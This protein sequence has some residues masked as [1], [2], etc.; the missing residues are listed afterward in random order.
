MVRI[1]D[2]RPGKADRDPAHNLIRATVI[3]HLALGGDPD[4]P[5]HP[6]GV[7]LTGAWIDGK[8]D[9]HSCTLSRPLWLH[10][11]HIDEAP[12]FID[13]SASAI[14]LSGSHVPGLDM[15]GLTTAGP[16][17]LRDGFEAAGTVD[18]CGAHIGGQLD[19]SD[20]KFRGAE[21]ALNLE[22]ARVEGDWLWRRVT[23]S[24]GAINLTVAQVHD[25]EHDGD[26]WPPPGKLY[27]DGFA[28]TGFG[29]SPG[30]FAVLKDWLERQP[31]AHLGI[32]FRPQPFEQLARVLRDT[33]HTED[34]KRVAVLKQ[35]YMRRVAWQQAY[36]EI[37]EQTEIRR[38]AIRKADTDR[39]DAALWHYRK[40]MWAD[41]V[42]FLRLLRNWL[43]SMIVLDG[44]VG[45]GYRPFRALTWALVFIAFGSVV[46][47]EAYDAGSMVPNSPVLLKSEWKEAT[48]SNP[49]DPYAAFAAKVPD[50]QPFQPLAYSVDSFVPLVDL[51][52]ETAWIPQVEGKGGWPWARVYLWCHIAIGWIVT[53]VFA[54]SVTGMV[55][56]DV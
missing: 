22:K 12:D 15:N 36:R 5:V 41:P 23:L 9:F 16:V 43:F 26:S 17:Y 3:Q 40:Q 1:A 14:G 18:L 20:G 8:L 52:Q 50:C 30:G 42:K 46:F 27:L 37:A 19:C 47:D 25:V 55:K 21:I 35:R 7:Q 49:A 13:A 34:A 45:Y 44:M 53:A 31:K 51:H 54:A 2:E 38:K 4:D 33:G 11:C 24:G 39:A 28:Y 6:K 29:N 48:R 10:D 32:D 56:K